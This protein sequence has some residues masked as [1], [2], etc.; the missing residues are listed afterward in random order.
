MIIAFAQRSICYNSHNTGGIGW[1]YVHNCQHIVRHYASTLHFHSFAIP[2]PLHSIPSQRRRISLLAIT[3]APVQLA[4]SIQPLHYYYYRRVRFT[5]N[6]HRA[7]LAGR[8][9]YTGRQPLPF[10]SQPPINQPQCLRS[11]S[12]F[13]QDG[14]LAGVSA[15]AGRPRTTFPRFAPGTSSASHAS[16][17]RQFI[18]PLLP[19]PQPPF[20]SMLNQPFHFRSFPSAAFFLLSPLRQALTHRRLPLHISAPPL[21]PLLLPQ[22][23]STIWR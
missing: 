8:T 17:F 4:A 19:Q 14:G 2:I 13:I 22:P 10:A 11:S 16:R 23:I 18:A 15:A 9:G 20:P 3:A 21:L 7:I 1:H 6:G 5:F 12:R